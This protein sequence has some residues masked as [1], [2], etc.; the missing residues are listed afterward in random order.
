MARCFAWCC[1]LHAVAETSKVDIGSNIGGTWSSDECLAKRIMYGFSIIQRTIQSQSVCMR[2]QKPFVWW[3]APKSFPVRFTFLFTFLL[4]M[5]LSW[6]C[7][8]PACIESG[9][10]SRRFLSKDVK[11][12]YSDYVRSLICFLNKRLF[13]WGKG[14]LSRGSLPGSRPIIPDFFFVCEPQIA[15]LLN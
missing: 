15:M 2:F 9:F 13:P 12:G 4:I 7:R 8:Y 11:S 6:W 1:A 10:E 14:W 3:T 5:D